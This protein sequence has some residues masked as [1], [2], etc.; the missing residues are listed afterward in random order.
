MLKSMCKSAGGFSNFVNHV[1]CA[2]RYIHS[3]G[4]TRPKFSGRVRLWRHVKEYHLIA[5]WRDCLALLET[6]DAV[7]RRKLTL[8]FAHMSLSNGRVPFHTVEPMQDRDECHDVGLCFGP[9]LGGC[10]WGSFWIAAG[11][12]WYRGGCWA[13]AYDQGSCQA[14]VSAGTIFK[15]PGAIIHRWR[16]GGPTNYTRHFPGNFWWTTGEH[17]A[18]LPAAVGPAYLDPEMFLLSRENATFTTVWQSAR[19]EDLYHYSQLPADYVDGPQLLSPL[20][21][22]AA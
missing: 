13:G 2:D 20:A 21:V 3:K 17:W 8:T 22:S 1:V 12:P 9:Q 16:G 4:I 5:H 14:L 18:T 10:F 19:K 15:P 6:H 11:S 7:V